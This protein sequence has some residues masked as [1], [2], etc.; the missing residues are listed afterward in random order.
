MNKVSQLRRPWT[1]LPG[2]VLLLLLILLPAFFVYGRLAGH[3]FVTLDDAAYVNGNI[4]VQSGLTPDNIAWAFQ[5]LA[6]EFWHPL[7][8]LS[9]MLDTELYGSGPGGYL[10]TN[11]LLHLFNSALIFLFFRYATGRLWESWLL[12]LIFAI[13]PLHVEP[14]AWISGR[15]EL[16]SAL[17]GILSLASYDHYSRN[18]GWRRYLAV[19]FFFSLGMMAKPMIVTLPFLLLLLD[20][21]PLR[22]GAG[23][24]DGGRVQWRRRVLEK[25]PL[26]AIAAG[27]L[28]INLIA[29][30]RGG[31]LVSTAA[32]SISARVSQSVVAYAVYLKKAVWPG[33]L[34][35]LYPTPGMTGGTI[36]AAGLILLILTIIVVTRRQRQAFF[37]TGWFWFLG[38]LVPVIGL[39][40]IGDFFVA[41]R[42]MYMPLTGILIVAVFG[43]KGM[44]DR[45]PRRPVWLVAVPVVLAGVYLPLTSF[46]I[47]TW[48]NSETLYNH[49]LMATEDNFLAHRALGYLSAGNN[50]MA[51]AIEHFSKATDIRPDQAA[52]WAT[53]GKALA[54][55]QQWPAAERAFA[56][57][58]RLEPEHP[59]VWFYLGCARLAAGDKTRALDYLGKS[60]VKT[61]R[62]EPRIAPVYTEVMDFYARGLY[63]NDQESS[64]AADRYFA[65]ALARLRVSEDQEKLARLVVDGY[66]V[67]LA[68][69]FGPK[70]V[71]IESSHPARH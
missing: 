58:A 33:A 18:R 20:Y 46:Q 36:A 62:R 38:T 21:W 57:A 27:G 56:R 40:K 2:T 14:V 59:A 39:V 10:L 65:L 49:A 5:T 11:L 4:R 43:L 69:F 44:I 60:L 42:Y 47:Q 64:S 19:L 23:G 17:F 7:T 22:P 34:T 35:P 30:Q 24:E 28:A 55:D 63:D 16:L 32:L 52:L 53:L 8:W 25:M 12:G 54:F 48:E 70:E 15:K 66:D 68:A 1:G 51:G 67:W 29:Q 41:D 3:D 45:L 31:G 37:F 61:G 50:D 6:A 26:L 13:H 71:T 9:Y